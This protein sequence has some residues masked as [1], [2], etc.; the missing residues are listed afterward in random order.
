M[1]F[2]RRLA[3]VLLIAPAV[4]GC[5]HVTAGAARAEPA[6]SLDAFTPVD[7]EQYYI[8]LRGGPSHQFHTP[9]GAGCQISLGSVWCWNN[10]GDGCAQAG[11]TNNGRT[12]PPYTYFLEHDGAACADQRSRPLLDVGRKLSVALWP[13]GVITCAAATSS[14]LICVDDREGHGFVLDATDTRTF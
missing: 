10:A 1:T 7:S 9:S 12:E 14:R 2:G 6:P 5:G 13:D 3:A 11:P 8:P 4:V